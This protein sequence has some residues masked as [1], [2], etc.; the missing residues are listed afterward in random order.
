MPSC[1]VRFFAVWGDE[2]MI[3]AQIP[4][5]L[6]VFQEER[7][8]GHAFAGPAFGGGAPDRIVHMNIV[9]RGSA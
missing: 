3:S 1:W 5:A 6:A 9:G 2:I 4:D 8:L 7:S